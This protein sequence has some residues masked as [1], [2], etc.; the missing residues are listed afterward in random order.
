M[1]LVV[2]IE[3]HFVQTDTDVQTTLAFGYDYW[4][5]YLEVFD[6]VYVLGRVGSHEVVGEDHFRADGPGVEFLPVPDYYGPV[7]LVRNLPGIMRICWRAA[8]L[9]DC[10]LLRSGNVGIAL[11]LCLLALRRP[12]AREVQGDMGESVRQVTRHTHPV[13]GRILAGLANLFSELQVRNACCASYV[14][15]AMQRR[16]PGP[17]REKEFIFSSVRLSDDLVA[18][19]RSSAAFSD[20][21]FRILSVGRLEREKGHHVLVEAATRLRDEGRTDWEMRIVGPGRQLGPL[22]S[23]VRD[24]SLEAQVTIAGPAAYGPELFSHYDWAHLFVL[25][26]LTEGMPRSLIEAMARGCPALGSA[27]GGIPE[28]LTESQLVTAGDAGVLAG[29]IAD[30]IDRREALAAESARN[31]AF[32][33]DRY[34]HERMRKEKH[35]FWQ[36]LAA[37]ASPK[38]NSLG[39]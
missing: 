7:G 16:Y 39:Q 28:L 12:Y 1:K 6:R 26:S 24:R 27:V 2:A 15:E 22:R 29:A 8:R 20:S 3:H 38:G 34:N 31:L 32:V 35:A 18:H 11:W 17:G 21:R 33:V 4:K 19:A 30:R 10:F 36:C 25:P 14:S 13:M 5:D 9:G 37:A 23:L